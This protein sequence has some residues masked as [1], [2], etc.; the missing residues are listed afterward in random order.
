MIEA[1]DGIGCFDPRPVRST[2]G[3]PADRDTVA[4]RQLQPADVQVAPSRSP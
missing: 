1:F 2:L 3:D 4:V